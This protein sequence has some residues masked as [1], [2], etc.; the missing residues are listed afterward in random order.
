MV[1]KILVVDDEIYILSSTKEIVE[2]LGYKVTTALDGN[3]ALSLLKK[4]KFD[5]VLLD[6]LMPGMT[7]IEVLEKIRKIP[8]LKTQ[9][10]AFSTVVQLSPSGKSFVS[11]LKPVAYFQKPFDIADFKKRI[12]I[13]L[14]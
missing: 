12:R 2:S 9:K 13:L 14:E 11:K 3:K 6:V 10:V 5:L 4:R 7:G 8:K 1:K